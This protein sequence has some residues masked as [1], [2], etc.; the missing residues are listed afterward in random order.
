MRCK[1][2]W[3][4]VSAKCINVKQTEPNVMYILLVVILSNLSAFSINSIMG[5][6]FQGHVVSVIILN[7]AVNLPISD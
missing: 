4:K 3:I 6:A 1:S 7:L 2:L 5:L